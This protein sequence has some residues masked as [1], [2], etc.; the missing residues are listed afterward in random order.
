[1][2]LSTSAVAA[3]CASA[4]FNSRVFTANWLASEADDA[5]LADDSFLRPARAFTFAGAERGPPRL[6]L[7]A[8]DSP[9]RICRRPMD[10]LVVGSNLPQLP[11]HHIA[12]MRIR[13]CH[14]L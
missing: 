9:R 2:A 4:W 8:F 11:A 5:S 7:F 10:S 3:C 1:M 14:E 6:A 12:W 13:L